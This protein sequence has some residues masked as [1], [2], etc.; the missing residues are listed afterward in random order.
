MREDVLIEKVATKDEIVDWVDE[1]CSNEES[2]RENAHA[3]LVAAGV[4]SIRYLNK[5]ALS[6]N[7]EERREV[8]KIIGE[9]NNKQGIPL[10]IHSLEDEELE[11]R[12]LAAEGLIDLGQEA[13]SPIFST[14][15]RRYNSVF[16][17]EG[18]HHVMSELK[19]RNVFADR[20]SI[21]S[22]LKSEETKSLVPIA[23]RIELDGLLLN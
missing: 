12:L 4:Q 21:I 17:R 1:L 14:L 11:I 22:L 6:N 16:I 10:L 7:Q 23:A 5:L 9:I 2:I 13:L 20:S 3:G 15:M 18:A 8:V 19:R